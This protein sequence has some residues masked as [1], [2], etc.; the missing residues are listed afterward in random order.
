MLNQVEK[1][2]CFRGREVEGFG[3][4]EN[5]WGSCRVGVEAEE[6]KAETCKQPR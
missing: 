3:E 1:R 5:V 4:D 2:R 6:V